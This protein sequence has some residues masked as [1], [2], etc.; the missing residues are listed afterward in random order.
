LPADV[1]FV[2][3]TAGGKVELALEPEPMSVH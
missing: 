1:V 3:G 2:N